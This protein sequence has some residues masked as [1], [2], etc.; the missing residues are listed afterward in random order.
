M[1]VSRTMAKKPIVFGK[2][3]LTES[4]SNCDFRKNVFFG[5]TEKLIMKH[6]KDLILKGMIVLY[7]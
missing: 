7:E 1:K 4:G 3:Q 5:V 6:A 2:N